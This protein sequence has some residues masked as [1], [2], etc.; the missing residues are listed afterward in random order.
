[1][2]RLRKAGYKFLP[3]EV[4][5]LS[6]G[7]KVPGKIAERLSGST[8]RNLTLDN[9]RLTT[10]L[11]GEEFGLKNAERFDD[12]A[13]DKLKAPHGRVYNAAEKTAAKAPLDPAFDELLAQGRKIAQF[14]MS[15]AQGVTRTIGALRRRAKKQIQADDVATQD[16]GYAARDLADQIEEGFGKRLA[17]T[18]NTE[19]LKQYQK[20]RQAFAKIHDVELS[21]KAGLVDAHAMKKLKDRGTKLTGR[22]DMIASA[23]EH[24]PSV[25][26]ISLKAPGTEPILPP[27]DVIPLLS[28]M[29]RALEKG[30]GAALR[31]T[32]PSRFDVR[33]RQFQERLGP[34]AIGAERAALGDVVQEP[35]INV[36]PMPEQFEFL[37]P[38][39]DLATPA[40]QIGR[41][42]SRLPREFGEQASMQGPLMDLAAPEGAAS[43]F[44]RPMPEAQPPLDLPGGMILEPAPGRVGLSPSIMEFLRALEARYRQTRP[45]Q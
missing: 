31:Y 36:R 21:T 1:V 4:E 39:M 7:A 20:S 14:K 32:A 18:N 29:L 3:S 40:G 34:E 42:P 5:K 11:A 38:G 16:A 6:P 25:T 26:K 35:N 13:F 37:G 9:Q 43:R 45:P 19:L 17:A 24:A 41:L 44:A 10:R 8:A 23:A 2:A 15:D 12:A 28:P 30:G 22:L 27:S 33:S